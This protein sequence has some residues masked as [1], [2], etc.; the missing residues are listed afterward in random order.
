M[1]R[2]DPR[3]ES[4]GKLKQSC[5][6]VRSS[7]QVMTTLWKHT[8]RVRA[9]IALSAGLT[10][11][12][13]VALGWL[14]W[15]VISQEQALDR[16]RQRERLEQTA[17]GLAATILRKFAE[18]EAFLA[19]G[20]SRTP[21]PALVDTNGAR[22]VH[23]RFERGNVLTDP[24]NV[25]LYYPVV[26]ASETFDDREFREADRLEFVEKSDA[27]LTAVLRRIARSGNRSVRAEALL[28][29]ARVQVRH[30][31]ISDALDTYNE[32]RDSDIVSPRLEIPY[33]LLARVERCRLLLGAKR[34]DASNAEISELRT[35]LRSGR[36]PVRKASFVY[37]DMLLD[38]MSGRDAT[39]D[40]IPL[41][42]AIADAVSGLWNDWQAVRDK[43]DRLAGQSVY[44]SAN[45][46]IVA[47]LAAG[48]ERL[49]GALFTP[50]T[51]RQLVLDAAS[52][53]RGAP[54]VTVE[55][56]DERDEP[57]FARATN[58][59][60]T[61]AVRTLTVAR[62]PWKVSVSMPPGGPTSTAL[63]T[64]DLIVGI[65][66][67]VLIVGVACYAMARGVIREWQTT[68]VQSDFVAAVSH[69]FRSPLTTLGQLTELLAERRIDDEARRQTYFEVM[70]KETRRLQ[71]LVENL[72]D[73]GRMEAN[74]RQY[75]DE[76]LDF[77]QVVRDGVRDYQSEVQRSGYEIKLTS[78]PDAVPV[79]GDREALSRVV[80]NLLENAVKYSPD[81]RTVWVDAARENG[82]AVL[83]VRDQGI[84]IAA[85]EQVRI[86]DKFVRGEAAKQACIQGTG[87]GL[88]M[89]KEVVRAHNGELEVIS[90]TGAGSTFTVRIP[91]TTAVVGS[92][93]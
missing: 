82:T 35:G 1:L 88:A 4:T 18:I 7:R 43:E 64:R 45:T 87:I 92:A 63:Q 23:V 29:L 73:F 26:L 12:V 38:Q 10:L 62:L 85:N 33:A 80:R 52:S 21:S 40:P 9:V 70:Q 59:S 2:R 5:G 83:A 67:V 57:V 37:Y 75:A 76:P 24:R 72:L 44:R 28:R 16:Q 93:G 34:S 6:A 53:Q 84:G 19:Q 36:W 58:A 51:M 89:V 61:R 79:R 77:A 50:D 81:C 55:L 32:L 90:D 68:R 31:R 46:T 71:R 54:A 41:Q 86:F 48:P 56:V 22:P 20:S 66:V 11:L 78:T 14:G 25:L 49:N 47:I 30:A 39:R 13:A 91:L 15:K 42:F 3:P 74:R 69:E 65:V 60:D 17:D 27:E 8:R